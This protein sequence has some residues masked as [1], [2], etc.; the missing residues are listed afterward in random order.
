M[1]RKLVT[2]MIGAQ[3]VRTA[4]TLVS[5]PI[6]S[7]I[8]GPIPYGIIS[9]AQSVGQLGKLVAESGF[10]YHTVTA[11]KLSPEQAKD[12][13]R[14]SLRL[15]A[16]ISAAAFV[17]AAAIGDIPLWQRMVR[18]AIASALVM[19][20]GATAVPYAWSQRE[21]RMSRVEWFGVAGQAATTFLLAIPL[22]MLGAGLVAATAN[23]LLPL[24]LTTVLAWRLSALSTYQAAATQI[25]AKYRTT[26]LFANISTYLSGN[27]GV[28][29]L[30][31]Y[32]SVAALGVYSRAGLLASLPG[33]IVAA[34]IA[35]VGLVSLSRSHNWAD[36]RRFL[37]KATAMTFG[38][39]LSVTAAAALGLD[40]M[41][42]AFG[43]EFSTPTIAFACLVLS[44]A[45][46]FGG[47]LLDTYLT[48]RRRLST[49]AISHLAQ[50]AASALLLALYRPADLL[51]I[52]LV[53][54]IPAAIRYFV[55]AA[56][57]FYQAPGWC[58]ADVAI[59]AE[60]VA[61]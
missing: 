23:I 5:G 31:M 19:I 54:L 42:I 13:H 27:V 59:H 57:I 2:S 48:A 21:G 37:L 39:Y 18:G 14:Q 52:G 24:A 32:L 41:G 43:S 34:A 28:L 55:L 6:L 12:L 17:I 40:L 44:Q 51:S 30:S 29:G 50:A 33:H 3:V 4:M 56:L 26:T 47:S 1:S 45:F 7:R 36:H 25:D 8:V 38:V 35:K 61:A 22:A 46:F 20:A 60:G 53:L 15:A 58:I 49:L 16:T 9:S 10:A 11:A